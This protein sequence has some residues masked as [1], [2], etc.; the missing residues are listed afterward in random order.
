MTHRHTSQLA[1]YGDA[2]VG[3]HEVARMHPLQLR[4]GVEYYAPYDA[5]CHYAESIQRSQF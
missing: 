5:D 1:A 2:L 4:I 3:D